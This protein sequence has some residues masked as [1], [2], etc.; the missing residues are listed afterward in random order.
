MRSAQLN[1]VIDLSGKLSPSVGVK[2]INN[3]GAELHN[4]EYGVVVKGDEIRNTET[5]QDL[6]DIVVAKK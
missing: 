2:A 1:E 3:R 5:V 6:F 4:D